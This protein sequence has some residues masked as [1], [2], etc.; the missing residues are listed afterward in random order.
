M[1][2]VADDEKGGFAE[3]RGRSARAQGFRAPGRGRQRIK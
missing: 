1:D 2:N 3:E